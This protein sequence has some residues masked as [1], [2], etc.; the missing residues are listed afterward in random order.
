MGKVCVVGGFGNIGL[1]VTKELLGQGYDV[2]VVTL[3][4]ECENP[5]PESKW[6]QA[7][8]KDTEGFQ[9]SL[10]GG[11]YEYVID[12]A[13]FT[14]EDAKVDYEVFQDVKHLIMVST[15]ASYGT[16]PGCEIPIREYMIQRPEWGYGVTKKAAEEF[17]LDKFRKE[18]Y[19]ITIFR[20]TVT[21]GRQ[22]MI[23]RQIGMD[24]SW[25]D[26]IRKGKPIVTGNPY[27]LRNFLY[28]DDAAGAFAGALN[29]DWC[30][31]QAYNL[32]AMRCYD[33]GTYHKTMMEIIGREVEMIEVP[34]KTLQASPHFVVSPMITTNFIYN[35]Y[36]AGDKIARDI[37]EFCP[38]TDLKA[39]LKKTLDY[40]D[41]R[42]LIPDSDELTWEDELIEA[43][44]QS[45][46]YLSGLKSNT[47]Q[48]ATGH[49]I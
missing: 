21:Y 45:I 17:F 3:P 31:G 23:V 19:P 2:T 1:G 32:G 4:M 25:I 22:N 44:R 26:R 13:C 28:A 24:N 15:G 6:I 49:Q 29:H 37:P 39:G 5:I 14:E 33:W 9:N 40:L 20:P 34:L 42:H 30:K 18:G 41:A 8:R 16:L 47:L 43:Q 35:G 27:I 48:Q 12:F 36:Y 11:G 38:K 10:K 46:V 7:D